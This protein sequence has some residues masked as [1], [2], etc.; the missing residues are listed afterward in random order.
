MFIVK[1]K[2][3]FVS[4]STVLVL[5]A[6]VLFFVRGLNIGIDFT[7]GSLLEVEYSQNVPTLENM[8]GL[9]PEAESVRQVGDSGFSIRTKF[10]SDEERNSLTQKLSAQNES[11]VVKRFSSVGPSVGQELRNKSILAIAIVL[12]ATILYVA[13]SFRKI[14]KPISSWWYG[15]IVIVT[16]IHDVMIPVGV[17][18]LLGIQI[19]ILFVS[20]LLAILGYSVNDTIVVFDRIREQLKHNRESHTHESYESVVGKSL[21]QT[22][23]RSINTS[24]T[25]FIALL[26]LL[27]FGGET[28]HSF[29]LA[30]LVGVVA[31]SYSSIFLA[32]PL[33]VIVENFKA[34]KDK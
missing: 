4:I 9:V 13:L 18:A 16:L 28:I 25:V 30:L 22:M 12:I 23:A 3:I 10:L 19:D 8:Q 32:S 6:I 1:Y 17:F 5:A 24:L 33:L 15:L 20:A 14:S 11:M 27:V 2:K 26:V 7:G 29:I 34:R 31:G 21:W